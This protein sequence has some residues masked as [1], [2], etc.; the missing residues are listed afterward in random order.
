M[1]DAYLEVVDLL[2]QENGPAKVQELVEQCK[3]EKI[4]LDSDISK[5][6][7]QLSQSLYNFD[8]DF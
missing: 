2:E 1:R 4:K 6:E 7:K 3:R 8:D 5:V